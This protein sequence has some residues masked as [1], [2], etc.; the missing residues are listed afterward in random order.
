VK[1]REIA[2]A[3]RD[4][5]DFEESTLGIVSPFLDSRIDGRRAKLPEVALM[6]GSY[7]NMRKEL[8]SRTRRERSV[9]GFQRAGSSTYIP[10]LTA[11]SGVRR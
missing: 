2:R 1:L 6:A 4:L 7:G 3:S 10:P 8:N 5:S 9:L 11:S